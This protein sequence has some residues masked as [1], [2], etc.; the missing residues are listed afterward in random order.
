MDRIARLTLCLWLATTAGCSLTKPE[1]AVD[2]ADGGVSTG[3]LARLGKAT[4]DLGQIIMPKRNALKVMIASR[5]LE[6]PALGDALW[7]VADEQAIEPELRRR[8][9]ANGLRMGLVDGTLPP[10]VERLLDPEA[11]PDDRVEPVVSSNPDGDST[12]I[13]VGPMSPLERISLFLSQDGQAIG[14]DYERA[15]GYFRVTATQESGELIGM[16]VRATPELHHGPMARR[17]GADTNAGPFQPQEF[18]YR[19]GQLEETFRD[20]AATVSMNPDQVLVLGCWPE[21]KGSLGHYMMTET[22]TG[23]DRVSQRVVFLW[24]TRTTGNTIPWVEPVEPPSHLQP[25]DPE[26]LGEG[27]R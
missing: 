14:K 5:P 16:K 27:R 22:E 12:L 21:R 18:I 15:K 3:A 17:Y 4:N 10:E 2:A 8:L 26:E 20:L 23:T 19:D 24:A 13:E 9:E 11:P 25:M 7:Q 1:T 6:D